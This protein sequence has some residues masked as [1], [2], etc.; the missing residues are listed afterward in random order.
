M[1]KFTIYFVIFMTI[2]ML[3]AC[4]ESPREKKSKI[5]DKTRE[6]VDA[7]TK[8]SE[9]K[10]ELPS[11]IAKN[12]DT[13]MNSTTSEP[14]KKQYFKTLDIALSKRS[15]NLA[16]LCDER[17]SV[18]QRILH[19]YGAIFIADEKVVAPPVCMFTN[20]DEVNSFQSKT[21]IASEQIGDA[22]IELQGNAMKAYLAARAEAKSAGLDIRPRGGAEAARRGFDDTLRL[23]KSRVDPACDHWIGKG[24]LTTEQVEKL[25]ALPIKEQVRT[26]LEY[27]KS[28]IY[29]NKQ[30]N[31]S[32]LYSVAAPGT[33]QHLS[34]LALDVEEFANK[35]V[36]EIMANHGWFRTVQNDAPHFTFL[37]KKE[38]ELVSLGL[39]KV[40]NKDGEF[41]IPNV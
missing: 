2:S 39:K 33:S 17:D 22:K 29:F 27:E 18:S 14:E 6:T 30:F 35:A 36:R 38:D 8:V 3:A 24:K 31:N 10:V 25:K 19:E 40:E 41:W 12:T 34:M 20:A 16:S 32:I 26:V 13:K 1:E 7:T 23:W 15:S 4:G 11:D 9:N 28:E 21:Q 37:G 5:P